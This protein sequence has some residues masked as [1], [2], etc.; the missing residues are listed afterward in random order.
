M[1]IIIGISVIIP[2]YNKAP[3]IQKAIESVLGQSHSNLELI[4]VNDGSTDNS[5]QRVRAINDSRIILID[6]PNQGV[7][8]AR[9]KGVSVAQNKYI[10]FLDG[11]DWWDKAFLSRM[12][13]L[14]TDFPAAAIYGS[15][16]F[17][18]K[19]GRQTVS[20]NHKPPGF[21]GYFDYIMAYT[22]AWWM[23]FHS[24]SVV[25]RKDIFEEMNGFKPSLKFGED[26][27]LWVRIVLK[28]NVAYLNEPLAYYNQDVS[29][30]SRA[31]G[32]KRWT[33][34]EHFLFNLD[35]LAE[36][37]RTNPALKKLLD[38]LRV[39]GLMR[40]YLRNDHLHEVAAILYNVDFKHQ[41][42]NYQL[43]YAWPKSLVKLYLRGKKLGSMAKQT[44]RKSL[45]ST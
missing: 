31:L 26:F 37:E 40:F 6:Q 41:P 38:G 12:A 19:N 44:M 23:P 21:A 18:V 4:I 39:R 33:P 22:Y 28:Y 9:N 3:Y 5:L 10:A 2:L 25:I 1:A 45:K 42:R 11:D 8:T 15:Q 24:I 20:V 7:S 16:Y 43:M 17:W 13:Q 14:I 35:Y 32:S 30:D 29:A 27:D 34:N 36:A